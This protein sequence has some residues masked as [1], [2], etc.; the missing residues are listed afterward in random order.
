MLARLLPASLLLP[1]SCAF[2]DIKVDS[3]DVTATIQNGCMIG[4]NASSTAQF[5]TIDFGS[6]PNVSNQVD[7]ASAVGSGSIVL[8]CTLS[9]TVKIAIDKGLHSTGSQRYIR[10]T[11]G[12]SKLAYELYQKS[13]YSTVWGSETH[14]LTIASFP[15]TTQTY[16][17][18]ARLFASGSTPPAGTYTDTV[19]VTLTY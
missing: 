14:A 10:L 5:G 3:F 16:T 7:V 4:S 19:T 9:A 17:V 1:L 11:G 6:R 8:T 15:E 13:D 18:Y 12:S 2:G